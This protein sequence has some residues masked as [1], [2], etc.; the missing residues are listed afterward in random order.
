M[1][2]QTF[3]SHPSRQRPYE[4]AGRTLRS[5][6]RASEKG[7]KAPQRSGERLCVEG[8][9]GPGARTALATACVPP[10]PARPL[11]LPQLDAAFIS[12]RTSTTEN[13]HNRPVLRFSRKVYRLFGL[14]H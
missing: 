9:K 13:K 14:G 4:P 10:R 12:S 11:C 8:E 3:L 1:L 7:K 2:P 6:E 5:S